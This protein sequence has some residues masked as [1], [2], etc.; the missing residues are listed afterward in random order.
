MKRNSTS[1]ATVLETWD[2]SLS[3][4]FHFKNRRKQWKQRNTTKVSDGN[5]RNKIINSG[6]IAAC[7]FLDSSLGYL[8]L[9]LHNF[10]FSHTS[11][12]IFA[13]F[14][15][16][17]WIKVKKNECRYYEIVAPFIF[18]VF[19]S[20]CLTAY[21]YQAKFKSI[22]RWKRRQWKARLVDK[23]RKASVS[24]TSSYCEMK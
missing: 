8:K 6:R 7:R 19:I 1:G 24:A 12:I 3:F 11:H 2:V 21:N 5:G 14:L 22:L 20:W 16:T 15:L 9:R 10:Q 13:M 23:A 18:I 17:Q 4:R